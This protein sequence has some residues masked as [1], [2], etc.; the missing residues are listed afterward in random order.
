MTAYR[1]NLGRDALESGPH[2]PRL[3]PC[4]RCGCM[5][6]T[7]SYLTAPCHACDTSGEIDADEDGDE[8]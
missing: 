4:W 6:S 2:E 7:G 1:S 3:V 5:G 8:Q